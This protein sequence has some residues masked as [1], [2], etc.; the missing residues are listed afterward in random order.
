MTIQNIK[1][2]LNKNME[3]LRKKYQAEILEIKRP[4]SQAK[5]TVEGHYSRIEQV[6]DRITELEDKIEIKE[7]TEEILL[8]QLKS[9]KRN[10]QELSNSIKSPNL[11]IMG[12]EEGEEVQ[13][14]GIC[15]IFN[16]II[17][18][19]FLNLEKAFPIQVRNPQ[20][21]KQT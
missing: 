17:T 3:N 13:A 19:N 11:R 6:E 20:D 2:E 5:T 1:Q 12:I 15:N 9:C 21:T 8:K 16:K 14:K 18:E 10:M 7:K 4:V